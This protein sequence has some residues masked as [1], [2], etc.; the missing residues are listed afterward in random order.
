M[1]QNVRIKYI[2]NKIYKATIDYIFKHTSGKKWCHVTYTSDGSSQDIE[3]KAFKV[4][5]IDDSLHVEF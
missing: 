4:S 1:F 2:D 5:S 3:E